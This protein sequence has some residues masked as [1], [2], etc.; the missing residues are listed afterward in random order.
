[1]KRRGPAL[2]AF[3][4]CALWAADASAQIFSRAAYEG[5]GRQARYWAGLQAEIIAQKDPF[6]KLLFGDDAEAYTAEGGWLL[7]QGTDFLLA[8][9]Y[10]RDSGNRIGI[11]PAP[12]PAYVRLVNSEVLHLAPFSAS[13]RLR[14]QWDPEQWLVPYA[15]GG[16][17]GVYFR[18]ENG[19]LA[20]DPAV[21]GFKWGVVAS[22]GLLWRLDQLDPASRR[23]L[24]SDG[25]D[26]LYLDTGF[27]WQ[28]IDDFGGRG[29]DLSGMGGRVGLSFWYR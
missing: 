23:S 28:W 15:R 5:E 25:I 18:S 8:A 2:A 6:Q 11:N 10:R 20:A 13:V 24:R 22:G 21:W 16:G 1:M 12:P 9:G 14:L 17:T 27:H 26:A 3:L 4:A 29:L 7:W 19:A